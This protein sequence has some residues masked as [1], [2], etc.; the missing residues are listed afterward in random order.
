VTVLDPCTGTGNFVVNLIRR[1]PKESLPDL[2]GKRLFANEVMLLPYYVAAMNI[3]HAYFE[4][5]GSYKP[6]EGLC[7]TDTLDLIHV[8]QQSLFSERNAER[9]EKEKAAPDQR[10]HR[11]PAV[12][13]WQSTRTTTTKTATTRRRQNDGIDK[14]V[15][16]TYTRDSAASNKSALS[17]PYV[18]FFRWAATG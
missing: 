14:R 10:D 18:K 1:S 15:Q 2:Y 6:F 8:R 5:V 9:I 17:D 7:F 12:Q 3:E 13:R 4:R 16:K 11:Q